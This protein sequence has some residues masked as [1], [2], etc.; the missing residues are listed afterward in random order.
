[1]DEENQPTDVV[2]DGASDVM[3]EEDVVHVPV[4]AEELAD[5]HESA[6]TFLPD[7]PDWDKPDEDTSAA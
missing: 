6:S 4:G 7:V 2:D 5:S 3:A 1:M